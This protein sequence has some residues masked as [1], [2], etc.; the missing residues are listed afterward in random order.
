M[1]EIL[2][3]VTNR[4]IAQICKEEQQRHVRKLKGLFIYTRMQH[5][6]QFRPKV[7]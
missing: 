3:K 5:T 4:E 2:L 1:T 6:S 7:H